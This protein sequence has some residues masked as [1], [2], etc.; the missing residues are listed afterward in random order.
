MKLTDLKQV[1]KAVGKSPAPRDLKVIDHL[2]EHAVR[3]LSHATFGF[4]AFGNGG[5]VR[6]TP[7]AGEAGFA[8]PV[9]PASLA[10]PL[11]ALD[12]PA[13]CAVGSSSGTLF[14]VS[15]MEETLRV[16]GTV[17]AIEDGTALLQVEECYLHCAKSFRRSDFWAPTTVQDAGCEAAEFIRRARFL[18]V[19][20][21][22]ASGQTDV[23]PK[24]DP[25]GLL[26]I[27]QDGQV[28]YADRPGNKRIDSFRNILEQ[29][30][31]S[32]LALIP[33]CGE[34]LEISGAAELLA[35]ET[36]AGQFEVQGKQPKLVTRVAAAEMTIQ[37]SAAIQGASLWPARPT[38]E[39]LVPADIF[40]AHVKKSKESSVHAKVARAA[41]TLPGAME[42]GL[43]LDYKKNM[44]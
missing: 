11:A 30:Q 37:P 4:L 12:H 16:N 21:S 35:D 23:S 31:V 36:L 43:E 39:E 10:I 6:I 34:V 17:S 24:G 41:V 8:R 7:A 40:K 20:S 38:P 28:C 29:P 44:Y 14:L 1:E 25:A 26:L 32:M 18:V 15:G 3:W 9:G 27:E 22:N 13:L 2:D 42:K 33:G 5:K 19:A